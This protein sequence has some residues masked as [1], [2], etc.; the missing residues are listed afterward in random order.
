MLPIR[1]QAVARAAEEHALA[2]IEE[3]LRKQRKAKLPSF[4][5]PSLTPSERQGQVD[6]HQMTEG[7]EVRCRVGSERG[8][9]LN[10]KTLREV[11]FTI[12]RAGTKECPTCASQFSNNTL[13]YV[14]R[15]CCGKVLC[16]RCYKELVTKPL[17][18][19]QAPPIECPCCGAAK[20]KDL[21]VDVVALH[22]EGTG[23][24]GG[25]GMAEVKG[26]G[27]SFQG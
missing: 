17:A 7:M 23:Y 10:M 5:L 19:S 16:A 21:S 25:G 4:W 14:M 24:A 20:I 11:Q 18:A 26:K 8:H 13:L 15:S 9:P 3:G 12:S 2:E 6:L 22:H 27:R 1:A